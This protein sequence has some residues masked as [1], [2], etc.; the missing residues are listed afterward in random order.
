VNDLANAIGGRYRALT[1]TAAYAGLQA[2]AMRLDL[3][4]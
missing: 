3:D 2:G 4:I 1:Y